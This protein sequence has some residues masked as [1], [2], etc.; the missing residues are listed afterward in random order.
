MIRE[1]IEKKNKANSKLNLRV[2]RAPFGLCLVFN[3][4][5]AGI[6]KKYILAEQDLN[7]RSYNHLFVFK[8]LTQKPELI[9]SFIE[10][11]KTDF[12]FEEELE[13]VDLSIFGN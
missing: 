6:R 11:L 1:V 13:K 4:L 5:R 2:S 12:S 8:H 10:D 3:K 7:G 9:Y